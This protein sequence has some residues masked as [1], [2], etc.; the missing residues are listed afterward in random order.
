MREPC[1]LDI[2]QARDVLAGLGIQ[3]TRRQMKRA[4]DKDPTGRRR[5][6]FFIDPVEGR[7]KIDKNTL[8]EIYISRQVAAEN[9]WKKGEIDI[10]I[11]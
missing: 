10:R 11:K 1:Y 6:P 8:I 4:T 5:L 9:T 7:L 3:L 2:D